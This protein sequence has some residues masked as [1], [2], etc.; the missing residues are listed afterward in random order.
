MKIK[1]FSLSGLWCD[2]QKFLCPFLIFLRSLMP[3]KFSGMQRSYFWTG[4]HHQTLA[5]QISNS[6]SLCY[7][8]PVKLSYCEKASKIWKKNVVLTLLNNVNIS[9]EILQNFWSSHNIW[10]LAHIA[11]KKIDRQNID[12]DRLISH[13]RQVI[14]GA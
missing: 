14:Y 4:F 3:K 6:E 11:T 7:S 2:L 13:T 9:W 12:A 8:L 5:N 1:L 10:T